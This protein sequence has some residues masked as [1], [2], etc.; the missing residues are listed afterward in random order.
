M[1]LV[2]SGEIEPLIIVGI[3]HGGVN[4][5]EEYLPFGLYRNVE[6][7]GAETM[8]WVMREVKPKIERAFRVRGERTSTAIGGASLGGAM[9][10]YGVSAYP[11]HFGMAIV[12]SL[13]MMGDAGASAEQYIKSIQRW[14]DKIFIGMGGREVGN[15][16]E[17]EERNEQYRKWA[18]K[19]DRLAG[20]AG[21]PSDARKLMIVPTAT[22]NEDAWAERFDNA[23]R[24]M[25]GK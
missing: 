16:P 23:L 11:D 18:Q 8:E 12:E 4:R 25:F 1:K 21:V 6:G 17:N 24:F 7:R 13:P 22:H 3:P 15:G 14:P 9:A 2:Q 5:L 19:V 20:Q 10:L